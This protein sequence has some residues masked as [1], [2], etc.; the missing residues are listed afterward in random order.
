MRMFLPALAALALI[1]GGC[2]TQK[3]YETVLDVC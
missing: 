1:V 2:A 3:T